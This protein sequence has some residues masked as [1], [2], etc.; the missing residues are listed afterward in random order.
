[1]T[2]DNTSLSSSQI[3]DIARRLDR[4]LVLVGLM[5][6]GKSTVG[7]RLASALQRD[8]QDADDAIEE[9]AQRSIA[10]IFDEFGEAY[11]RDGERRVIAR[12]VEE[13]TGVIATGG[14]AFADP[15]TRA[16][17]LD[18]AVAVWIDAELD[19][20]VERTGR[21]NT[22]PLLR[23]G[24]PAEIL[25]RLLEQRRPFY[26]EAQIKVVSS[27]GPHMRTVDAILKELDSWL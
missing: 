16:L 22:R 5:G 17:I 18:K 1:M 25:G 14:G 9:A 3:A 24:D 12:L 2:A 7:R 11:F 4:P 10:E 8:F 20:L 26:A 27:D 19:T 23:N 6:V 13:G 15:E 21:R